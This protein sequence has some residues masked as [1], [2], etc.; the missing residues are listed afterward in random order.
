MVK[1]KVV[2]NK[3][4]FLFKRKTTLVVDNKRGS[5]VT[6]TQ[7]LPF[8]SMSSI[9]KVYFCSDVKRDRHFLHHVHMRRVI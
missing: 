5:F 3:E 7:F 4:V 1:N 8:V 2:D 6:T 9:I